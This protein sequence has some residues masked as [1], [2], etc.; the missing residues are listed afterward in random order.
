MRR[1]AVTPKPPEEAQPALPP[2][3]DI[4]SL[5]QVRTRERILVVIGPDDRAEELVRIGKLMADQCAA[6]WSVACVA[7]PALRRWSRAQLERLVV[8]LQLAESLGAEP[9]HIDRISAALPLAQYA[10]SHCVS[11]IVVGAPRRGLRALVRGDVSSVLIDAGVATQLVVVRAGERVPVL[12]S[13]TVDPQMPPQRD[14]AWSRYACALAVCCLG[15]ALAWPLYGR[16]DAMNI[17]MIYVLGA[18]LSGLRLGRGPAVVTAIGNVLALDYFFVPPRF[19]LDIADPQYLFTL[20]GTLAV[21][22]II[23]NL[24]VSVRR[25]TGAAVAREHRTATLYAMS[26]ELA[27]AADAVAIADVAARHVGATLEAKAHVLLADATGAL[28]H[29]A[30]TVGPVEVD[31]PLARQALASGQSVEASRS[32]EASVYLPLVGGKAPN[33]V[34]VVHPSPG[35]QLVPEQLRL[36]E[37]LAGQLA[38]ALERARLAEL[39][40]ESR[41]AAE[42]AALRNTLLASISH[43]LRAP[44]AAIASAGSLVAQSSHALSRHRRAVLG[45]LIE[46]KAHEMSAL[47]S[48]VLELMRLES[49]AGLAASNWECVE[50]LVGTAVKYNQ[51]RLEGWRIITR[52]PAE[53]PLLRVDAQLIV[54]LISNLLENCSKYTAAGTCITIEAAVRGDGLLLAVDDDG[55]GFG[56]REP[57]TLFEKFTRGQPESHVSGVGLGL[58]ICRAIARLHGG[59]ICAMNRPEGGARFETFL[60]LAPGCTG[61]TRSLSA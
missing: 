43:D 26:R 32:P 60:P 23:S 59:S 42:R 56:T 4:P 24:V 13:G 29:D 22:L 51:H 27:G 7:S 1:Q 35:Q 50:E 55:P 12:T 57:E 61:D 2:S 6:G 8:A 37:T 18:T 38:L 19:S 44:L 28:H 10:R 5:P 47:L 48:N 58:A 54:Q 36:L 15:T 17:A 49:C 34:L 3:P 45:Q 46:Q 52:I 30:C 11:R 53:L 41:A 39:A 33:G 21:A 25:Q 16:V 31:L 14:R 20:V 9:T 40:A